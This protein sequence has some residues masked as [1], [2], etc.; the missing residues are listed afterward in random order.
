MVRTTTIGH[1]SHGGGS[2]RLGV[3]GGGSGIRAGDI[4]DLILPVILIGGALLFTQRACQWQAGDLSDYTP[5][6]VMPSMPRAPETGPRASWGQRDSTPIFRTETRST[7]KKKEPAVEVVLDVE[8]N[9]DGTPGAV[10]IVR[11]VGGTV[12]QRAINEAKKMQYAAAK[13]SGAAESS[14]IEL[15]LSVPLY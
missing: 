1:L 7:P 5:A 12:D 14:H 10:R 6:R 9:E 3:G 8:V 13:R 2:V 4:T 11:G 15:K